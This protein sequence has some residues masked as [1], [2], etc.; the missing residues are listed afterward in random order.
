MSLND[1]LIEWLLDGPPWVGM[2]TDF[3]K[4]KAPLIWYDLLHVL[5]VL[6][7]FP[8]LRKDKRLVEMVDVMKAK[9]DVEGRFTA[10]SVWKAWSEW[11]FGQKKSPSFLITLQVYRILKRI[12]QA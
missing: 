8:T 1:A 12:S 10:E 6:S 7:K 5:E 9:S 3:A 4:L 2:G 11:E